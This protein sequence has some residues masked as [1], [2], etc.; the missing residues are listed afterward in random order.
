MNPK[1]TMNGREASF[2]QGQTIL[3]V[4]R[5]H[6]VR[7]PTLCHLEEARP[8]GL[9][10]I[11]VV[12]VEGEDQLLPACAT[13]A[14]EGMNVHTASE[15]VMVSRRTNLELLMATGYHS[16]PA[17]E[18]AGDCRLQDLAYEF[19]LEEI[20]YP[21]VKGDFPTQDQKPLI[22]RDFSKCVL[23]G[24]C[25]AA[26]DEI[27]VN[28]SIPYSFGRREDHGGPAGWYPLAD[29]DLC[30]LCGECVQACPVG[31]L[32]ERKARG[33][34]RT[35]EMTRVLAT[36]PFGSVGC[37]VRLNLKDG[38]LVKVDGDKEA[39]PNRGRL[40]VM[41]RFLY[42]FVESEDRLTTPLIREDGELREASWEEALDLVAGKLR[43]IIDRDGPDAIGGIAP[44][45]SSN[46]DAFQ[47]QKLFR[48]VIGTNNIDA[49]R[50]SHAP[51]VEALAE[52]FGA[53]AST[54]ALA[55]VEQAAMILVVGSGA[56]EAHPVAASFIKQAARSGAGLIVA[57]PAAGTLTE[58]AGLHL[59]VKEGDE[60]AFLNVLMRIVIDE[61]LY[62]Q[63]YVQSKT[64]GFEV[65][66][67][68]LEAYAPDR[69]ARRFG[70][71][72][73]VLEKAARQ[74]AAAKP[75]VV[76][77]GA[78]KCEP[79]K[80]R[81]AAL[82]AA[83]LQ[84]L[85]GN[86][87]VAGGGLTL[88]GGPCNAQGACDMGALPGFLPGG[89]KVGD[90]EARGIFEKAWQC[91]LPQGPGLD[92]TGMAEALAEGRLKALYV[93]GENLAA[94]AN[95]NAARMAACLQAG[96]F[97]IAQDVLDNETTKLAHV[98]LP[99]T[100]WCEEEGTVTSAERRVSLSPKALQAPGQARPAW[101]IYKEIAS[102]LGKTWPE[103]SARQV[104]EEGVARLVPALAGVGYGRLA[105]DGLQWPV[106]DASHPGT[107][108]LHEN[109]VF[110]KGKAAFTPAG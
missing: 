2:T 14:G 82:A 101:W 10:R 99:V 97:V 42:D 16:C 103:A 61:G 102:R 38:R 45:G 33:R 56:R 71:E 72:A 84:L 13:P 67:K 19:Q 80:I 87:G 55:D 92:T 94:R 106:P 66:K 9:C 46:E 104:W 79:E 62:D 105:G 50:R 73:A 77:Y 110:S 4:A 24:R 11:C 96:G 28:L 95:P 59:P 89:R 75:A 91:I 70:V 29:P 21:R 22:Y 86:V 25:M 48:A 53:G 64:T 58:F 88:L 100:A 47:M 34:G 43:E 83:N 30:V 39:A 76:V 108:R 18:A 7:I 41:G 98:V 26:C 20:H 49:A 68:S 3:D 60:A 107:A 32:L 31:A 78:G 63:A 69:V 57:E 37:R 35:W 90:A 109:G 6:G 27:Q 17:C 93:S 81:Q 52:V 40:C 8:T 12:E 54:N 51:A 85:L 36:C 23:C 1:L 5:V 44:A 15:R 74:L 65:L